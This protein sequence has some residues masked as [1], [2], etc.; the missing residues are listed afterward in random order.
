MSELDVARVHERMDPRGLG[1]AQRFGRR[2]DVERHRARERADRGAA[3]RARH[4]VHRAP[5]G[6]RRRREA[7]LD[8]VDAHRGERLRDLDLLRRAE[9]DPRGLLPVAQ[10]G[11]EYD[12]S[13]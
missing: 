1:A 9:A 8:H 2:V 3:H 13:L 10:G 5:L 7:G 6:R 4:L 11:I 12:D